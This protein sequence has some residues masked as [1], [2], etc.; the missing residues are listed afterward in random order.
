MNPEEKELLTRLLK[1]SE[2]NHRILEKLQR[3]IRWWHIWGFIKI[4]IIVVPL[5]LGYLYL[6]P[7][8]EE[9]TNTFGG[10]TNILP[11]MRI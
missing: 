8:I 3:T 10:I 5:V 9:L 7:Y 4:L 11:A 6:I 2:E 1:L